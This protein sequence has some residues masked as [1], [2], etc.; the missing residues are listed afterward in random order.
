MAVKLT[1]VGG[2]WSLSLSGAVDIADALTLHGYAREILEGDTRDVVVLLHEATEVD[3]SVTQLLL[4]LKR[5]LARAGRA[6]A[7][8]G[9]PP[10]VASTWRAA[11]LDGHLASS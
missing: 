8:Q 11:G 3:T 4:V 5:D 9:A 2:E 10:L 7:L 6:C 1:G